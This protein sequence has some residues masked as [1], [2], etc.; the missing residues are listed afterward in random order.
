MKYNKV[1]NIYFIICNNMYYIIIKKTLAN[2][3]Y[4]DLIYRKLTS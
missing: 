1:N 2:V 3:W 4:F